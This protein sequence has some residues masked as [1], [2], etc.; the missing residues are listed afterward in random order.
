MKMDEA[1]TLNAVVSLVVTFSALLAFWHIRRQRDFPDFVIRAGFLWLLSWAVWVGTW[2]AIGS[3]TLQAWP[4]FVS[5][6]LLC[7]DLNSLIYLLL[8]FVVTRA[9]SPADSAWRAIVVVF[10][11]GFGYLLLYYAFDL[12]LATRLH[13][14]WSLVLAAATPIMVGWAIASRYRDY[15]PLAVG[16]AYGF[17]QPGIFEAV[18]PGAQND[19]AQQSLLARTVVLLAILKVFWALVIGRYLMSRPSHETPIVHVESK[20]DD[21]GFLVDAPST[22][23]VYA[24]VLIGGLVGAYALTRPISLIEFAAALTIISIVTTGIRHLI[25]WLQQQK[26]RVN[27]PPR[28]S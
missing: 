7:S 23:F 24:F 17:L 4:H 25:V 5:L 27:S 8:Y 19:T 22:F 26:S 13:E 11:T 2:L 18:F 6:E 20:P 9:E 3:K 15:L 16:F 21:T 12:S 28:S 14:R 10:S 1:K